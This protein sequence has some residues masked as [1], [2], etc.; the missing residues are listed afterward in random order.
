MTVQWI[1]DNLPYADSAHGLSVVL[2]TDNQ[3][4]PILGTE[5]NDFAAMFVAVADTEPDKY[6]AMLTVGEPLGFKPY[7][8]AWHQEGRI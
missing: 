6:A 5:I 1:K 4:N 3:G 7:L 8:D 2:H